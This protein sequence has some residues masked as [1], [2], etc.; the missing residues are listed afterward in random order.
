MSDLDKMAAKIH[1]LEV[2]IS[3][4]KAKERPSYSSGVISDFLMMKRLYGLWTLG[5]C[6]PAGTSFYDISGTGATLTATTVSSSSLDD[7]IPYAYFDGSTDYLYRADTYGDITGEMTIGCW[8]YVSDAS[9]ARMLMT[10]YS[11]TTNWA[12]RLFYSQASNVF[13]FS[14]SGTGAAWISVYS[15]VAFAASTWYFVVGKYTPSTSLDVYVNGTITSNTTSIPASIYNSSA[16]F[17]IGGDSAGATPHLGR[18][19]LAFLSWRAL[20][21]A[22]INY[23]YQKSR[24]IYGV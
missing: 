7:R 20:T 24:P 8:V 19:S 12:Y 18:I 11:G 13:G 6:N 10:K 21:D 16:N 5:A 23:Y 22:D 3:K 17:A 9:A 2:E 15:T 1:A 14:V 4:L